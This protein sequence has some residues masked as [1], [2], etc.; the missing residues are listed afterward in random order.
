MFKFQILADKANLIGTKYG[1]I[2]A[3]K[4]SAPHHF[5]FRGVRWLMIIS[6]KQKDIYYDRS[7]ANYLKPLANS[8]VIT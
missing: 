2:I 1:K 3:V 8:M 6:R 7:Y 5:G 4:F